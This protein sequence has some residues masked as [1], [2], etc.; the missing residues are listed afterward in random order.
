MATHAQKQWSTLA[1]NTTAFTVCFAVWTM[2]SIIG[3]QI[4]EELLLSNSQFGLMVAMPILSGSISRLPLG[5]LTD[6]FGGRPVFFILMIFVAISSYGLAFAS[7]YW[8]YLLVG[9]CVGLAG[10]SFAVGIAYTSA[11]FEKEHQGLAMGIFGSG[12]IGAALT[13][14]TA[15]LILVAYGWRMVPQVY[16]VAMALMAVLFLLFTYDDPVHKKTRDIMTDTR[17]SE[18]LQPLRDL[19]VW[20]FSLYYFI[21]F[22]GFVALTLWLPNYYV[23]EYQMSL[24]DASFLTLLFTLPGALIRVFG[25]WLSDQYGPRNVNW[26]VFWVCIVALFFLSYPPTSMTIHGIDRDIHFNFK[27]D[28]WVFSALIFVVGMS[29]GTGKGSIYRMIHDYY[30]T[31]MG[32]VG[33]FVGAVGALGG[34]VLPII[35]GL[36]A[37]ITGIRTSCF[38]FLY[39]LLGFCMIWMH[40]AIKTEEHLERVRHAMK[41]DFLT[42]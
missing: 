22:G 11:W 34:F 3:I 5:L 21:V 19:R 10:G 20:R 28:V 31:H 2:F 42:E 37:D 12:H 16:G 14:I 26:A 17:L 27:V 6:Y 13:N 9:L 1:M 24:G 41:S 35:F 25:G 36:T 15:P 40:Y 39:G 38:M 18:R 32:V 30:P 8:H 23:N 7:A 4:K 29:M 33:G